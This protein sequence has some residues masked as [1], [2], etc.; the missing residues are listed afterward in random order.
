MKWMYQF[1]YTLVWHIFILFWFLYQILFFWRHKTKWQEIKDRLGLFP[2]IKQNHQPVLWFHASSLGEVN[3][4]LPLI[5]KMQKQQHMTVILSTSTSRGYTVA[6]KKAENMHVHY[7]P[8]DIS[9]IMQYALKQIKPNLVVIFETEIWPNFL[10]TTKKN[11]IPTCIISARLS[12]QSF[13]RYKKLR[14]FFKT[15]LSHVYIY[16]QTKQDEERYIAIGAS[17]KKTKTYGDIKLDNIALELPQQKKDELQKI[18]GTLAN[19]WVIGS[20]HPTEEEMLIPIH[21]YLQKYNVTTILAPRH[22]QRIPEITNYLQKK[23]IAYTLRS[24]L[25]QKKCEQLIILDTYGELSQ[26]YDLATIVFI[27]GTLANIGGHNLLESAA[28]GKPTIFGSHIQNSRHQAQMLLQNHAAIQ[29]QNTEQLQNTI[30]QLIN[31][32]TEREKI[33]QNAQN[34]IRKNKGVLD[35]YITT[36]LQHLRETE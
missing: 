35:Q 10:W 33:K 16:T 12:Q 18:Y 14:W 8:W 7:I 13:P 22:L 24:Q 31:N 19:V 36:L 3:S 34:I 1:I 5:Q 29:I 23:N 20:T 9:Y 11:N 4:I 25:P 26:V 28:L 30:E 2:K 6:L 27:G 32:Q 17:P 15:V 21:E